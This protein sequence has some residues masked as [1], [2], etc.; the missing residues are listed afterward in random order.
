MGND[1][2]KLAGNG[3]FKRTFIEYHQR[4]SY[5]QGFNCHSVEAKANETR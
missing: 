3:G 4:N 2:E 1:G 5:R